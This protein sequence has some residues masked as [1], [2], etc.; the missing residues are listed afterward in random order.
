MMRSTGKKQNTQSHRHGA[1][2]FAKTVAILTGASALFTILLDGTKM[3]DFL[4]PPAPLEGAWK[5]QGDSVNAVF[6]FVQRGNVIW[7]E[8]QWPDSDFLVSVAGEV[9]GNSMDAEYE[10]IPPEDAESDWGVMKLQYEYDRGGWFF[11]DRQ[12]EVFEGYWKSERG[13]TGR[14]EDFR[15]SANREFLRLVRLNEDCKLR[16]F[17]PK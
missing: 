13:K 7:G 11:L 10:R 15:W 9:D 17:P 8:F 6:C 5:A 12:N 14:E 1:T 3:T 16:R 2:F 4:F